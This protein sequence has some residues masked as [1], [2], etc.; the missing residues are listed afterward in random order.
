MRLSLKPLHFPALVVAAL[1]LVSAACAQAPDGSAVTNSSGDH[2]HGPSLGGL[3][4]G[5]A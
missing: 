4:G 2:A 1:C 5:A 3:V